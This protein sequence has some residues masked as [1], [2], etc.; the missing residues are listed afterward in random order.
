MGKSQVCRM[1]VVRFL[2][3]SCE[4]DPVVFTNNFYYTAFTKKNKYIHAYIF[5]TETTG[6]AFTYAGGKGLIVITKEQ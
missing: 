2:K 3:I 4:K 6:T 1:T 5:C